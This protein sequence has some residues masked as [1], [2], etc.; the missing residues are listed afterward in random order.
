MSDDGGTARPRRLAGLGVASPVNCVCAGVRLEGPLADA[1]PVARAAG[2]F[3]LV[4]VPV[5]LY[6]LDDLRILAANDAAAAT[7]GWSRD[8]LL[9]MRLSE[10]R[11]PEDVASLLEF[12]TREGGRAERLMAEGRHWRKDG[13]VFAVEVTSRPIVVEGRPARIAAVQDVSARKAAEA[14]AREHEQRARMLAQQLPA[15]LWATDGDLRIVT[16]TGAGLPDVGLRPG[17]LCGVPLAQALGTEPEG[18]LDYHRRALRGESV[19]YE[20]LW[21]GRSYQVHLEARRGPEGEVLG[22][23][24]MALDVTEQ[25]RVRE[26]AQKAESRLRLVAG[27]IPAVLWSTDR[28]LRFTWSDGAGLVHL[29]LRPNEVVG[30]SIFDYFGT[31]DLDS[32]PLAAHLSALG[33]EQVTFEMEH[34]GRSFHCHLEP[35]VDAAGIPQGTIGAALDITERKAAEARVRHQAEY[36]VVTDL[37]N[38]VLFDRLLRSALERARGVGDRLAVVFL[39]LD[40]F[41]RVNDALGHVIGDELLR[42]AASRLRETVRCGDAVARVGGDEFLLLLP[43]LAGPEDAAHVAEKIVAALQRPLH[44]RGRELFAG[45]SLGIAIWPGDGDDPESLVKSAD[46]AMYRA[47]EAGRG[48]FQFYRSDDGER[49]LARVSLESDLR[50]AVGSASGLILHYQAQV[51][52][53]SGRV[54]GAEG[55][56]RWQH[57]ER[58]LLAPA[59][60]LGLATEVGLVLPLGDQV[61][62]LAARA[63]SAWSRAGLAGGRR[64]AVNLHPFE[65]RERHLLDRIERVLAATGCDPA[66]L[67]LEITE[68][69]ALANLEHSLQTLARL[70]AMGFR[71]AIDDFGTGHSSLGYLKD[72]PVDRIKIDR[73]F[74]RE[75]ASDARDRAIVSSIVALSHALG[76]TVVAEGVETVEQATCL[77][78]IGCDEAQGFLFCRPLPPA[79]FESVLER[80]HLGPPLPQPGHGPAGAGT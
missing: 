9:G 26:Q 77:A 63:A 42:G 76:L 29:G 20:T 43:G 62:D 78:E 11:P 59:E 14:L 73:S 7:Y 51:D 6:A 27:Q 52:I 36:D 47:K 57:A 71:I 50:R 58:G 79:D 5:F 80:G 60:F 56:V 48:T 30:L 74:V 34:D 3:D 33:G 31:R 18:Y 17:Q 25:A 12:L 22:V 16:S 61:L 44:V 53:A 69:A 21:S 66:L 70:R 68:G 72:L 39:D 28:E 41:K 40:H 4:P 35:L 10:I 49:A 46:T 75:I 23:V 19:T 15:I 13:T 67:E 55:L 32:P 1:C 54:T 2:A 38:R 65:L 45:A 24:G 37:P 64:V 8:E